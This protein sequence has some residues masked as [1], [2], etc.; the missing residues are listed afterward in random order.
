LYY[1]FRSLHDQKD[2]VSA[3]LVAWIAFASVGHQFTNLPRCIRFA[4]HLFLNFCRGKVFVRRE[5]QRWGG[6]GG[7]AKEPQAHSQPSSIVINVKLMSIHWDDYRISSKD[8]VM[9]QSAE[10]AREG[11]AGG[12][13]WNGWWSGAIGML[14]ILMLC[15]FCVCRLG[16]CQ[17]HI[18]HTPHW[19][20]HHSCLC[21]CLV[22]VWVCLGMCVSVFLSVCASAFTFTSS[23]VIH[24]HL[25]GLRARRYAMKIRNKPLTYRV[26]HPYA[27]SV[28][29]LGFISM[30]NNFTTIYR[31][32][33]T[34][35]K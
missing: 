23:F 30:E 15:H 27:F 8:I 10:R 11:C 6:D 1:L 35:I 19:P 29:Y 26:A 9:S 12:D 24:H 13:V 25:E 7:K 5:N 16:N 14:M 2:S 33:K 22:W 28:A 20:T 18:A 32:L 21:E 4:L 34:F 31:H 17:C 3:N